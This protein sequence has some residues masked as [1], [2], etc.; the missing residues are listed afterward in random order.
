MVAL[1]GI[2]SDQ[3]AEDR[4]QHRAN[5]RTL[6]SRIDSQLPTD[7][8]SSSLS[9][10]QLD[11]EAPSCY[12]EAALQQVFR[13]FDLGTDADC[14][15]LL[16][17]GK[18]RRE[19]GQRT[20]EWTPAMNRS[21]LASI[22]SSNGSIS[23]DKFVRHL[24]GS[25]PHDR[26][27]FNEA[28]D[29][30]VLCA[31]V[32][33]EARRDQHNRQQPSP[34]ASPVHPKTPGTAAISPP[35][36]P[37]VNLR[38]TPNTKSTHKSQVQPAGADSPPP[39]VAADL[40]ASPTILK[41]Y[42]KA[43][44]HMLRSSRA[45][46][47][48]F[49]RPKISE[50]TKRMGEGSATPTPS[51]STTTRQA[52]TPEHDEIDSFDDRRARRI[53]FESRAGRH[54]YPCRHSPGAKAVDLQ[55][56]ECNKWRRDEESASARRAAFKQ[57]CHEELRQE[58]AGESRE[59]RELRMSALDEVYHKFD[60]DGDGEL[61]SDEL[62][63]LGQ[64]RRKLGQKSG[65]WTEQAN[66]ALVAS[67]GLNSSGGIVKERFVKHFSESLPGQQLQFDREIQQ[68]SRCADVLRHAFDEEADVAREQEV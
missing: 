27:A 6:Q 62:L 39:A 42:T 43:C 29:Q 65:Q 10:G 12:R 52:P 5:L 16:L 48:P 49:D 24:T 26:D 63:V 13:K 37:P 20:G 28:I 11:V 61:T 15:R 53:M 34:P 36:T 21:L 58:L 57:R 17:L 7:W 64:A 38:P 35:S 4:Q 33:K 47:P 56:A 32:C 50:H 60:L 1:P 40:V 54:S 9:S 31:V 59:Q 19:L 30:L 55:T 68:M 46:E 23:E 18:V 66:E 41:E 67:I 14:V 8:K 44:K 2:E 3:M 25:L 51:S 45:S 22:Y